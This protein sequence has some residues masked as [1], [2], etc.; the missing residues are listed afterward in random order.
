MRCEHKLGRLHLGGASGAIEWASRR[1]AN[2]LR[3]FVQ[4]GKSFI[5]LV[6]EHIQTED[7][8]LFAV[9]N[10]ALE[11]PDQLALRASFEKAD[12]A[13]TGAGVYKEYLTLANR[14]IARFGS[15]GPLAV[16]ST[17]RLTHGLKDVHAVTMA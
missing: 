7:R 9:A 12:A 6:R 5:R 11:E 1:D 8:F 17:K 13:A 10:R 4:H 15:G 16:H 14:L 2:A 3:Q